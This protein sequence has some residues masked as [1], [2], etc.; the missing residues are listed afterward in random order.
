MH[1]GVV[2]ISQSEP[3]TFPI[4]LVE[5]NSKVNYAL[6]H[7]EMAIR[8]FRRTLNPKGDKLVIEKFDFTRIIPLQVLR[9]ANMTMVDMA[10]IVNDVMA[11]LMN[12]VPLYYLAKELK[13]PLVG[14]DWGDTGF[15]LCIVE[16]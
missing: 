4:P 7:L 3:R 16:S 2:D 6:T 11:R 9:P 12:P 5:S 14:F 1:R 8:D 15:G 10:S 13:R